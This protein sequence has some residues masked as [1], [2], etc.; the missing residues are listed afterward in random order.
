MALEGVVLCKKT[1]T[2]V[3]PSSLY[4]LRWLTSLWKIKENTT[5]SIGLVHREGVV[6]CRGLTPLGNEASNSCSFNPPPRQEGAEN[7]QTQ[8]SGFT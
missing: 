4:N 3:G 2:P 5:L 6:D 8:S 7:Q 1:G